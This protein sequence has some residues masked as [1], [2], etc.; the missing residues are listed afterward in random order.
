[1][2]LVE[3]ILSLHKIKTC[4]FRWLLSGFLLISLTAGI[5]FYW[6]ASETTEEVTLT[7]LKEHKLTL[8]RASAHI[9]SQFFQDKQTELLLLAEIEAIERGRPVETEAILED[10]YEHLRQEEVVGDIVRVGGEGEIIASAYTKEQISLADRDYFVWAKKQVKPGGVFFSEP[11]VARGG[12]G[13]GKLGMVMATPIFYQDEFNGLLLFA[14]TLE[15]L[16]ERFVTPLARSTQVQALIIAQNGRVAASTLSHV[17][18]QDIFEYL[19]GKEWG[20]EELIETVKEAQK[21]EKSLVHFCGDAAGGQKRALSTFSPVNINQVNW[22]LWVS[23]PYEV[24]M[25][26]AWPLRRNQTIGITFGLLGLLALAFLYVFGVRVAQK[27]A[28]IDGFRNGRDGIK[29]SKKKS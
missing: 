28:F 29:K 23:S 3:K 1:M 10:V 2:K 18:G 12:P 15:N 5:L 6:Q 7:R 26:S 4:H 25:E 22:V 20:T 19:G 16:T 11:M 8:A 21:E 14:F 13:K 9:I 24:V 27:D 17:L